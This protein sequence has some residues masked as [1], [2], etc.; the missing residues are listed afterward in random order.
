MQMFYLFLVRLVTVKCAEWGPILGS[1]N[2][3]INCGLNTSVE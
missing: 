1:T 3:L 2:Y